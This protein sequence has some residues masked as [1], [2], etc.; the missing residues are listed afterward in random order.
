MQQRSLPLTQLGQLRLQAAHC[1]V[2]LRERGVGRLGQQCSG[3][4]EQVTVLLRARGLGFGF[5]F[6]FGLGF[7]SGLG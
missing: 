5:G 3:R 4:D 7:G 1:L 2:E 6:G